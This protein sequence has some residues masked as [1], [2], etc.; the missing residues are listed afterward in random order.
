MAKSSE[1]SLAPHTFARGWHV[2]VE[3]C[4]LGERLL[5]Q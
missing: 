2:I 4:E 3:A 1:Y 5:P